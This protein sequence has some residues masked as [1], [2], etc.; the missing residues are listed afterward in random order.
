[1]LLNK[2]KPGR[3]ERI[4][5][6]TGNEKMCRFLFTLGFTEGEEITLVSKLAKN[7]IV[8]IKESRYAIDQNMAE[9][10]ELD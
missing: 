7:Y 3:V 9:S 10:I 5:A 8:C 1:M 6:V 4:K 2:A